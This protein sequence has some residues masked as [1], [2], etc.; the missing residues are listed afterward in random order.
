MSKY[1]TE[2]RFICETYA[3]YTEQQG[4]G[5]IEEILANSY[6]KIFDFTYPIFDEDYKPTLEQK[7]LRHY[8]TREISDESVGLWKQR[9]AAKMNDIM[10][11]YNDMYTY[12]LQMKNLEN[13]FW[14]V[15]L[16]TERDIGDENQ[17]ESSA[18]GWNMYS[19]T[20]QGSITNL[21]DNTYLTNA[22][23][24]TTDGSVSGSS[25]EDYLER[26]YGLNGSKTYWELAK[27][28]LDAVMN[29]D[30]MIIEDLA[31]LFFNLW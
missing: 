13:P 19:D 6:D 11:K 12:Y 14:N 25:T 15:D 8:Y 28:M 23:K 7:I 16:T 3:G 20:P 30:M 21:E 9:L 29:I 31:P 18:N 4:Y 27:D 22:T 1:T 5:K 26:K 2:V 17:S 10:P 24:T